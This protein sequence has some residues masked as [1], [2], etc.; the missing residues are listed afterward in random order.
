VSRI[1]R[2]MDFMYGLRDYIDSR[3]AGV[4]DPNQMQLSRLGAFLAAC[5]EEPA[6]PLEA[7]PYE[8]PTVIPAGNL[9]ELLA[10]VDKP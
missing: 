5:L 1:D 2:A 10:K 4:R 6:S 3:I 7:P 9:L 8:T